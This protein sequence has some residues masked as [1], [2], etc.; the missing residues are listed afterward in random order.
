MSN[1]S[2]NA[3]IAL[4]CLSKCRHKHG[5]ILVKR[6]QVIAAGTNIRLQVPTDTNWRYCSLHAEEYV[7]TIAGTQASGATLY[8][9]RVNNQGDTRLSLPCE[10]CRKK[11]Y[12]AKIKRVVTT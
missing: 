1:K 2:L 9:A 12:R 5:A 11:I 3:A 7:L 6:G 10:R 4:A 8:V